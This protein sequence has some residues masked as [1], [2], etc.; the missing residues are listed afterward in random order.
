MVNVI[1]DEKGERI[2]QERL[3]LD[4]SQ[5]EFAALFGKKTMAAFRYEKGERLMNHADLEALHHAG[6]DVWYLITG[7]R[8]NVIP[9]SEDESSALKLFQS[10]DPTQRT[11]LLKLIRNFVES[12]PAK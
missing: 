7:E 2:R 5:T 12:F 10:V 1:T 3:R 8:A 9:L 4:L 6:V 11:T